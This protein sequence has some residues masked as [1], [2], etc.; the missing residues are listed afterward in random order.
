MI[1]TAAAVLD[2]L[3]GIATPAAVGWLAVGGF[4]E[5][6]PLLVA[7]GR[8]AAGRGGRRGGA[9]SPESAGFLK[10]LARGR[11]TVPAAGGGLVSGWRRRGRRAGRDAVDADQ[12]FRLVQQMLHQMIIAQFR[13]DLWIGIRL[14]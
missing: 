7:R 14:K 13:L 1:V 10:L 9:R 11:G 2:R 4:D 3:T 12:T 6:A 5:A 8:R